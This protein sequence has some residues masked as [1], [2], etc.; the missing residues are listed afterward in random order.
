MNPSDVFVGTLAT[1][2]G[3]L[4]FSSA[5][6]NWDWFFQLRKA[7]F[8][9]DRWGRT[10][11]RLLFAGIG[12]GLIGLGIAIACGWGPNKKNSERPRQPGRSLQIL[13]SG[14]AEGRCC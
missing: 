1:L 10:R 12:I 2:I 14:L 9:D 11:S 3:G 8:L 4:V 6:M 13:M 5:L 7:K